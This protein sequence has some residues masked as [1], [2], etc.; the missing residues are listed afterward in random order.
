LL[1]VLHRLLR[2]D[3][4]AQDALQETFLSAFR[5]LANFD[6]D[7]QIGTWLHRIA[8]NVALMK[9]RSQQRKPELAIEDFLPTF[10]DD[11]HRRNPGPA[12][13][14][15]QDSDLEN[16]ETRQLVRQAIDRLPDSYRIVLILR[17]IEQ[18]D[19]AEAAEKLQIE[20]GALNTRL[21]RARQA[22]RTLLDPH[23]RGDAL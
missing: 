9:L 2:R 19:A 21:H 16:A 8:V 11:G 5:G 1:A 23:F 20:I 18:L 15:T 6:G 13:K 10:F 22:L 17:D 12:W 3:E 7:C 4:D 14:L